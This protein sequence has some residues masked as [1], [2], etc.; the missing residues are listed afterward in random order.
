MGGRHSVEDGSDCFDLHIRT[1]L[2]VYFA[3]CVVH[4]KCTWEF[5]NDVIVVVGDMLRDETVESHVT[6]IP[7]TSSLKVKRFIGLSKGTI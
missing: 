2:L 3:E 5:T 6:S 4:F 1:K 7:S